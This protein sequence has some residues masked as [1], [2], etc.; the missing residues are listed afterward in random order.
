MSGKRRPPSS[1]PAHA[2]LAALL[3]LPAA[4]C[5]DFVA[6]EFT[7]VDA[8]AS[9]N[10][11]IR[12]VDGGTLLVDGRLVPGR[13]PT[14]FRREVPQPD[15]L[16]LD[17]A[18]APA[19]ESATALDYFADL[20]ISPAEAAGPI[21]WT[22]PTVAEVAAPPSM[23]WFPYRPV[24]PDT[25]SVVVGS[26]LEVRLD[27]PAGATAPAPD[28]T[29]WFVT[30]VGGQGS[31]RVSADGVPPENIRIPPSFLPEPF[32]DLWRV[33]VQVFESVGMVA[34]PG[35]YRAQLLLETRYDWLVT[36]LPPP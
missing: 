2:L 7:G 3:A 36:R 33:R 28:R 17:T 8:P 6:P 30:I 32:D 13:E 16:V 14:G 15:V 4:G 35:D 27:A 22:A 5:L 9:Y 11:A 34:P 25:F 19:Q 1:A 24:G 21:P 12:V 23:V 26:D 18:L 10:G 31:V 20:P 29:Q